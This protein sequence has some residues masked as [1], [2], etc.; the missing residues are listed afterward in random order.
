MFHYPFEWLS[1]Q[2]DGD[3]PIITQGANDPAIIGD[4]SETMSIYCNYFETMQQRFRMMGKHRKIIDFPYSPESIASYYTDDVVKAFCTSIRYY[5]EN[6]LTMPGGRII[7]PST[8]WNYYGKGMMKAKHFKND[9]IWYGKLS[10]YE[11]YPLW[12]KDAC[13]IDETKVSVPYWDLV[14]FLENNKSVHKDYTDW[15]YDDTIKHESLNYEIINNEV[16]VAPKSVEVVTDDIIEKYLDYEY[17]LHRNP[18]I[19][20]TKE[21]EK[22]FNLYKIDTQDYVN[23]AHSYLIDGGVLLK[24]GNEVIAGIFFHSASYR[25]DLLI[26]LAYVDKDHRGNGLHKQLHKCIDIIAKSLNRKKIYSTI[27]LSNKT[28]T[29]HSGPKIGY[30]TVHEY[31]LVN[32]TVK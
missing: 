15:I 25:E 12:F 17:V 30:E 28:M 11:K 16:A 21:Y 1:Q 4:T 18:S 9:I 19:S 29:E 22:M 32:R 24:K 20:L 3:Y 5:R 6:K 2:L 13:H 7:D 8:Y 10:G 26:K 14:D 27:M 23:R 31:A